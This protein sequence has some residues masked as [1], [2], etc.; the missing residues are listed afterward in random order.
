MKYRVR[1]DLIFDD[2]ARATGL[3]QAVKNLM[4]H[5]T[6]IRPGEVNEERSNF[7]F[8]RCYHD[9]S[10]PRPCEIIESE[11]KTS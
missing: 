10:P 2:E 9:E 1:A 6:I 8:E 3:A 11:T 4:K 5:A 7:T